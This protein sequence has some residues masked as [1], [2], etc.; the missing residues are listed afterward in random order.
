MKV[1]I[2]LITYMFSTALF[3][4]CIKQ[5]ARLYLQSQ[6]KA[7]YNTIVKNKHTLLYSESSCGAKGCEYFIYSEL[8]LKCRTLTLNV[9]GFL[10][11]NSFNFNTVKFKVN[12][13]TNQYIFNGKK[14]LVVNKNE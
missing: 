4:K 8:P 3:A 1:V 6:S 11:P 2:I 10:I 7:K 9:K 13:K 12:Q 5:D 14:F